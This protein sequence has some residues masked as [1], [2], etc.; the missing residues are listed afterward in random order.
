[1]ININVD[2]FASN[3]LYVP[4]AIGPVF[5]LRN[6]YSLYPEVSADKHSSYSA[7]S[8]PVLNS[9]DYYQDLD[10][11]VFKATGARYVVNMLGGV[12]SSENINDGNWLAGNSAT[13]ISATEFT[14][15]AS[16]SYISTPHLGYQFA[17]G[18]KV[19]V[20]ITCSLDSETAELNF[21]LHEQGGTV[22]ETTEEG[23]G[24]STIEFSQAITAIG[25][26]TD[27]KIRIQCDTSGVTVT[28]TNI[29]IEN[30][31][32]YPTALQT[33]PS[34]YVSAG[35]GI[36]SELVVDGGFDVGSV[37]SGWTN[38][39]TISSI[40]SGELKIEN[41]T[42]AE[43]NTYWRVA[44]NAGEDYI[45]TFTCTDSTGSSGAYQVQGESGTLVSRVGLS[46]GSTK[47]VTFSADGAYADLQLKTNS[48]ASGEYASYDN[49]SIKSL[50]HN[51]GKDGV[52]IFA[53]TN[54][55]TV[56]SGVVTEAVGTALTT[57]K[58]G[59]YEPE[60]TN[61]A[62]Y[63]RDVS[64]AAWIVSRATKGTTA[65]IAPGGRSNTTSEIIEDSTASSTH[66]AYQSHSYTSGVQYCESIFVKRGVGTRNFTIR[67]A[68]TTYGETSGL[69]VDLSD[70]S[71]LGTYGTPDAYGVEAFENDWY[72]VWVTDTATATVSNNT[73][74]QLYN[75]GISYSGD[76]SS[77]LHMWGLQKEVG[78]R[79]ST[80]IYTEGSSATRTATDD[81]K[82]NPSGITNDF[83]AKCKVIFGSATQSFVKILSSDNGT[84]G[85]RLEFN[86]GT[87][88][89]KKTASS[90]TYQATKAFT[91]VVGTEYDLRCV[92]S[93][94]NGIDII[95]DGTS[96]TNHTN[97]T[98]FPINSTVQIGAV[99]GAGSGNFLGNISDVQII[100]GNYTT[101][102]A[103]LL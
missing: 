98:D 26:G 70:G 80:V 65:V 16:N 27:S 79:P 23:I 57:M 101:A 49:I 95:V 83:V 55:N 11:D 68:S 61:S 9:D 50:S 100:Q 58:G 88:Y 77:S 96:G 47:T 15:G 93:S 7:G 6:K 59:R 13:I 62:I 44:T 22:T 89:A 8:G 48:A 99:L 69:D 25:D 75:G 28:V 63:N 24:T 92:F 56:S 82:L 67:T 12:A 94:T 102:E 2:V 18:E 38:S 87:I 60:R 84:S 91:P 73:I 51:A 29:Q 85:Y 34:E 54:A 31:T 72:R 19:V 1:M 32:A 37:D 39:N 33:I 81:V 74:I 42:A 76:G 90:T 103:A 3:L 10:E 52:K 45:A 21:K 78:S 35:V 97:V 43:G 64:N 86:T 20:R 17:A 14:T 66:L 40:V 5:S 41:T 53:T 36:G 4:A 71:V 30:K 46:V